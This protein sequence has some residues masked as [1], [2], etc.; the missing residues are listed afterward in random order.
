MRYNGI[1]FREK[2]EGKG[3]IKFFMFLP[4]PE[5]SGIRV[6]PLVGFGGYGNTRACVTHTL[7]FSS[8][9]ITFFLLINQ[10][11]SI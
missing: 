11:G 10:V 4:P 8:L 3:K 6:P 5:N 1:L 9:L 7:D 2:L